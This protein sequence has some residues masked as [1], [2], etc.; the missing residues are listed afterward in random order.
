MY[1]DIILKRFI[2]PLKQQQERYVGVEIELPIVN[3]NRAPVD[4][5]LVH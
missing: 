5:S 3:L 2:Q 1:K 4:F